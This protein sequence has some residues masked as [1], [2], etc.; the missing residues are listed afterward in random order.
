MNKRV[1]KR[2]LSWMMALVLLI[3]LVPAGAAQAAETD[4]THLIADTAVKPSEGGHLQLIT[5]GNGERMLGD[6]HGN[7]I[8]LR[9]MSTH[10]LQW[11]PQILNDNAFK[12]LANDW[13]A[14]VIRL[15]MYVGEDGYATKPQVKE[16]VIKGIDLAIANDM[17]V[18]VDW[19]VHSPGNP[20]AAVYQGAMDFFTEISAK[21]KNNKHIIYEL[22]NEPNSGDGGVAGGGVTNDAD[23]WAAVKSYAEPIVRMLRETGNDNIVIVGSPNWS[24]RADLAALDP[25]ADAKNNTMYTVHFY[26]GTHLPATD[27]SDRNN[28]MSNAMFA[29]E[30]GAALFATEWGTSEASG[31]NGPFLDAADEWLDFLAAHNISWANW[32]LTNKA[33]TSAAFTALELGKTNATDLDPGDD[34]VWAARE[35]SLSGEYVR[36]RIKGIPYEPIDRTKEEFSTTV[37]DFNDGTTQG[38][39]QNSDSPTALVVTNANNQLQ[40]AGLKADSASVWDNRIS[41]NGSTARPDILGTNKI[42]MDVIASAPA[43]VSIA[44]IPQ[45]KSAGW[46]NPGTPAEVKAN[47]YVKV[48]EGVYKAVITL[49]G[50]SAANLE[51]IAND[52]EDHILTN[53]IFLIASPHA[54]TI[55][56]DNIT[57]SGE[58]TVVVQPVEHAP[59]GTAALPSTFE[60][61]TR[62][63][64]SWTGDSGF[65]GALTVEDANGSKALSWNINY[66]DV[67][68]SDN[69]ASAPRLSLE[70]SKMTRGANR[71]LDFDFYLNPVRASEGALTV[72]LVFGAPS[73]SYWAQH[74]EN[75]SIP[76]SALALK[77]KTADGLYRYQASFDLDKM[78]GIAPDTELGKIIII[79]ADD[80][81]DYAGRMYVDNVAFTNHAP[82]APTG[83]TATPGDATVALKW[84]A[85]ADATSYNVKRST[86]SGGTYATLATSVTGTTYSDNSAANGTNYFYVVS[87]VK[88]NLESV[89]SAEVAATPKAADSDGNG[90]GNGNVITQPSPPAV[91]SLPKADASGK[92]AVTIGSDQK[93]VQ[94]A[95]NTGAI[96]K[97]STV[98]IKNDRA[99]VTIPGDVIL[100]LQGLIPADQLK[101]AVISFGMSPVASAD[102]L[103]LLD[104]AQQKYNAQVVAAGDV[105][106][107]SLSIAGNDGK[108][109]K[110]SRFD[111]PVT[112]SLNANASANEELLGVYYI[113][114]DGSLEYMGGKWAAGKM[115]A[116]ITHFSKY[117]VLSYDKS[118]TDVSDSFWA[119]QAIKQMAARHIVQGINKTEFAPAREVTRAEFVAMIAHALNLK[120]EARAQFSDVN[121]SDWFAAEAAAAGEA[122]IVTGRSGNKFAPNAAIT[123]EEMATLLVRAYT[124]KSGGQP[125]TSDAAAFADRASISSWAQ[126]AVQSAQALGLIKGRTSNKFVPQGKTTRAESAQVIS[127]LLDTVEE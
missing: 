118:F 85:T 73:L 26:T 89:N 43:A 50:E 101:D 77:E 57:F 125:A 16:E 8:Q 110:L 37:W 76:L 2:V 111:E 103:A 91:I 113:A 38:F 13:E 123:R 114:D 39:G 90:N 54:S 59:A 42:T 80:K 88:D 109:I 28:V 65:K 29:L 71:Y 40:I 25:I 10:G 32:S 116:K 117:A 108:E 105:L 93:S 14:N 60:D 75:I 124:Y 126:D 7:P 5:G 3:P 84:N 52:A 61:A 127:R 1:F 121:A 70:K 95:A 46:A 78:N 102:S 67:K 30:H 106:E 35:L 36:A 98:E 122:G 53:I 34:H 19:H 22:A 112:I 69:W 82:A 21:Y 119:A 6:E 58:R 18:I 20:N 49:S 81:S 68:P 48:S 63:G 104:R 9:G 15:A 23:G 44:A 87:A 64:W 31:N 92:I 12:A 11:F 4:Y 72:N 47:D 96:D 79:V 120:T 66:P 115:T 56:L 17:Y 100:K 86:V 41:A 24:Q 51:N 97:Q 94:F 83:L 99:T 33:E 107:F 55:S 27:S 45:S 62:Q 74:P